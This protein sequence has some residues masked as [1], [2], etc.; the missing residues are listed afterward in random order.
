MPKVSQLISDGARIWTQIWLKS[1]SMCFSYLEL[2]KL[3]ESFK[4]MLVTKF[5]K[6]PF[7]ISSDYFFLSPLS[8]LFFWGFS[9]MYIGMPDTVPQILVHFSSI[10]LHCFLQILYFL[11]ICLQVYFLLPFQFCCFTLECML[12]FIRC[13][14][15]SIEMTI[16]FFSFN[17]LPWWIILFDL[18]K[19]HCIPRINSNWLYYLFYTLLGLISI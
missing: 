11:I 14:S 6:C 10:F 4:L 1:W 2:I 16:W 7:I 13:F 19:K 18:L 8:L 12:N 15:V 5:E 9:G 3:F 17:L